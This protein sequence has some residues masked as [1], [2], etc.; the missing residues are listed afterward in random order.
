MF[1]LGGAN[2]VRS[3]EEL[4]SLPNSARPCADEPDRL[5]QLV[6]S[7]VADADLERIKPLEMHHLIF[8]LL[9]G[10]FTHPFISLL[11]AEDPCRCQ[12]GTPAADSAAALSVHMVAQTPV[13]L[14]SLPGWDLDC[15]EIFSCQGVWKILRE[16]KRL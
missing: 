4:K 10:V 14:L 15:R 16:L 9:N 7:F 8:Y 3:R 5:S 13:V 6:Q 11:S 1:I 2:N 12:T